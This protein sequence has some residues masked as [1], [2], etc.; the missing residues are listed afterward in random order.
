M[1]RTYILPLAAAAALALSACEAKFGNDAAPVNK[2]GNVSA[3]G[4]AEDGRI[5]INAPGFEMKVSIPE[6]MRERAGIDDHDGIIYP[7]STFSGMHVQRGND[8]PDGHSQGAV[9]LAFTSA[10]APDIVAR[11]YQDPARGAQFTIATANRQGADFV[12]AGTTKDDN[13]QFQVRLS[14][15]QAGGSEARINL[16]DRD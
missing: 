1:T 15:R 12:I 16:T 3:E 14:P 2:S 5:S 7:N 9:E 10:D 4:K 11:W 8:R 13:S 6:G